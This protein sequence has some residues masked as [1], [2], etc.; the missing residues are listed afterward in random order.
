[1][2]GRLPPRRRRRKRKGRSGRK[3]KSVTHQGAR[4]PF[5]QNKVRLKM[6]KYND[7]CLECAGAPLVV[8]GKGERKRVRDHT[9]EGKRG[10]V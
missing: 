6:K 1:M 3:I 7:N 4:A 10:K 2:S 8:V 9:R 5:G